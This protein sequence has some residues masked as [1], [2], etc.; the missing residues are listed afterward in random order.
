MGGAIGVSVNAVLRPLLV[1]VSIEAYK[2]V[3]KLGPML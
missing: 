3:T 2:N 1:D